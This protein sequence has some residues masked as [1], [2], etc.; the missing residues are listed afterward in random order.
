MTCTEAVHVHVVRYLAGIC[1]KVADI[2]CADDE[3]LE[4]FDA[5]SDALVDLRDKVQVA[6]N[7]A[8]PGAHPELLEL[9]R[10]SAEIW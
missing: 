8:D 10:A 5:A 3:T 4:A 1:V 7:V 9:R 6:I 2:V